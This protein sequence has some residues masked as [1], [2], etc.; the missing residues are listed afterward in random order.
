MERSLFSE[1]L[2]ISHS[3]LVSLVTCHC[4]LQSYFFTFDLKPFKFSCS[5]T[6]RTT[7]NPTKVASVC[8]QMLCGRCGSCWLQSGSEARRA[9]Q[10]TRQGSSSQA[11]PRATCG[12]FFSVGTSTGKSAGASALKLL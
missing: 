8:H 2:A 1:K 11:P 4:S 10:R 6:G 5:S 9:P 12:Y 3:P 7:R